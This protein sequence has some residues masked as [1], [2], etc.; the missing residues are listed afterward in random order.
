M[1]QGLACNKCG[2]LVIK[3]MSDGTS[4]LRAKVVVFDEHNGCNA[5][6]KGCGTSIPI[7]FIKFDTEVSK[8]EKAQKEIKKNLR[9][10]ISK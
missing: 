10:Y 3:S 4:K 5:I 1:E 7:P 9:L 6:C 8:S 2:E